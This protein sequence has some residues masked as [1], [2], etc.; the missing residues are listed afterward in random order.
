MRHAINL[1][2]LNKECN[3]NFIYS[4]CTRF[5]NS[6]KCGAMAYAH[7]KKLLYTSGKTQIDLASI[8]G[9]TPAVITNLFNGT[10]SLQIEEVQ[11]IADY[12]K[13]TPAF[14]LTGKDVPQQKEQMKIDEKLMQEAARAIQ[15]AAEQ[16]GKILGLA[17]AMAYTVSLYNDIVAE[18]EKGQDVNPTEFIAS[19]VLKRDSV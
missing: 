4:K 2:Y 8:I 5:R 1:D 10:R 19:L 3:N 6:V 14:V 11:K 7:L 12:F 18:R 13:V 9:R 15:R 17:Q 16:S